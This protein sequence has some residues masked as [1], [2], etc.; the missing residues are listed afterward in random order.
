MS[1]A[2]RLLFPKP[3]Q[4]EGL[5]RGIQTLTSRLLHFHNLGERRDEGEWSGEERGLEGT[6]AVDSPYWLYMELPLSDILY[7]L[8]QD[9]ST[10]FVCMFACFFL[11]FNH[12][13]NLFGCNFIL[14]ANLAYTSEIPLFYH[15]YTLL[16]RLWPS[17][18]IGVTCLKKGVTDLQEE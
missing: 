15:S 10:C 14:I 4:E 16:S 13:L 5:E 1:S 17:S 3:S 18:E 7:A 9:H 6:R 12:Y 11:S 2:D 8:I